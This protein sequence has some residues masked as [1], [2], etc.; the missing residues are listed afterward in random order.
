VNAKLETAAATAPQASSKHDAL[1][2]DVSAR[3]TAFG[4]QIAEAVTMSPE[5][6]AE[7]FGRLQDQINHEY[8]RLGTCREVAG[9]FAAIE[10]TEAAEDEWNRLNNDGM[11]TS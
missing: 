5:D 1:I 4:R 10:S 2:L 11:P 3:F 7:L 8:M 9:E 6:Q